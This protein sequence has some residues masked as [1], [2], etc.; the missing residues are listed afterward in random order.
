MGLCLGKT[1][2]FL[3][4][5]VTLKIAGGCL[6]PRDPATWSW[7]DLPPEITDLV[8]SRLPSHHDR[9]SLAAVCQDWRLATQHQRSMLPPALPFVC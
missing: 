4:T 9:L 5:D 3:W 8:F 2:P 1:S 6:C 7:V